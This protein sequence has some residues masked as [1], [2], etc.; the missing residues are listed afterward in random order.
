MGADAEGETNAGTD[1]RDMYAAGAVAAIYGGARLDR[2]F[3]RW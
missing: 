3:R 1:L 2:G